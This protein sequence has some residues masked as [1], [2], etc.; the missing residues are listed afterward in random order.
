VI[1]S[2][3]LGELGGQA[4]ACRE[5]GA[6]APVGDLGVEAVVDARGRAASLSR[7]SSFEWV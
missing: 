3:L 6:G 2:E 1:Q 4:L 5:D 7:T